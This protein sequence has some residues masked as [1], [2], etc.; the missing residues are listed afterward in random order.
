MWALALQK[1]DER[2]ATSFKGRFNGARA[3]VFRIACSRLISLKQ[4]RHG[5]IGAAPR[6]LKAKL[7]PEI[8]RVRIYRIPWL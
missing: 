4:G 6:I 3:N 7:S 1:H 8:D 2:T 5:F